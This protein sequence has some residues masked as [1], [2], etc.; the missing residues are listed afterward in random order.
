[1]EL[2]AVTDNKTHS[3]PITNS[4]TCC[5]SDYFRRHGDS[6]RAGA[7]SRV[8]KIGLT[9]LVTTTRVPNDISIIYF[10]LGTHKRANALAI[11]VEKILPSLCENFEAYGFEASR[12]YFEEA[13]AKFLERKDV[14]LLNK[15]LCYVLPS[16]GKVRLFKGPG[17]GLGSS[18]YRH[19]YVQYEEVEAIRFSD[20]LHENNLDLKNNICLLRMKK[21]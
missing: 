9:G 21:H 2:G 16:D 6:F 5:H 19:N 4:Q 8:S 18:I 1:M 10:D 3:S 7:F 15:A 14:N 12:E 20:W 13:R 11:M 17:D